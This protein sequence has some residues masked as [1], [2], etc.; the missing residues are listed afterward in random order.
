MKTTIL[1][2]ALI[3]GCIIPTYSQINIHRKTD[4]GTEQFLGKKNKKN[5][6]FGNYKFIDKFRD[7]WSD[8]ALDSFNMS[9]I[10]SG[11]SLN[12][13]LRTTSTLSPAPSPGASKFAKEVYSED[14]M[15]CFKP[16]SNYIPCFNPKGLKPES[17]TWGTLWSDTD[18]IVR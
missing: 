12:R 11:S 4:A 8:R 5:D 9:P 18:S 10:R 14:D 1:L 17:V 2:F 13:K 6:D 3:F 7:A 15:P 16:K